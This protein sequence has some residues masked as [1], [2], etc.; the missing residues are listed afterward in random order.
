MTAQGP[1]LEDAIEGAFAAALLTTC[2]TLIAGGALPA[3]ALRLS[4][5]ALLEGVY[6]RGVIEDL[7]VPA[8][9]VRRWRA[10]IKKVTIT[11]PTDEEQAEA[12]NGY[13]QAM[14]MPHRIAIQPEGGEK[15]GRS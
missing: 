7:G 2:K 15:D 1:S 12:I 9:T 5:Y 3:A 10:E 4:T 6:G 11:D 8:S 14:K 13:F